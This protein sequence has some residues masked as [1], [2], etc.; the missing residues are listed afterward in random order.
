MATKGKKGGKKKGQTL[1]L[2]EFL[3][4]EGGG[5]YRPPGASGTATVEVGGGAGSTW[6]EEMDDE[7]F[8]YSRPKQQIVLPTAPRAALGPD[9]DDDR[10]PKRPPYTAYIA[11]LPYDVDEEQVTEV[12]ANARLK[13]EQVR[14]M[15]DEG[16]RLRGY[17]YADFQD[18]QSLV[19]VLTMTDLAVNN[20]KMRIDLA[21]QAGKEKGGF[22]GGFG[23]REGGRG[24]EEDPNAGR[25]DTDND[26]R[27]GPAPAPREE[28][29]DSGG[30]DRYNGRSSSD[31]DRGGRDGESRGFSSYEPP[32]DRGGDR[33]GGGGGRY[34]GFS[35]DSGRDGGRDGGGGF[36]RD[37]MTG[38]RGYASRD[39]G[40]ERE[41]PKERP[42]LSLAPRSAAKVDEEGGAAQ[43]SIF[44]GAKPVDTVKKEKEMEEKLLKE[45]EEK[46]KRR[47]EAIKNKP[48]AASIFGGAKPVD[49]S[50]REKEM[51]EKL[52]K[53]TVSKDVD[54]KDER[55]REKPAVE[56]AWRRKDGDSEQAPAR[57]GAYQPPGRREGGERRDERG[58]SGYDRDRRDDRG[59]SGYDRDRRDDRGSDRRDDRGSSGYD[60]DR[61]DDRGSSSGYDRDR[62]DDRG[63]SSGYDRDRRDDRGSSGYDRDRRDERGSSSGYDREK[64][65]DK[66]YDSGGRKDDQDDRNRDDRARSS[67]KEEKKAPTPEPPQLKKYE[68]PIAPDVVAPNKFAFLQEEEVGSG[69]GDEN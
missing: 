61:R 56:N 21:S 23:D 63:S 65:D 44:G 36:S 17:G 24:R 12:F 32:R 33:D 49:T 11:N 31:R 58:S 64:R 46:E 54:R 15:K 22:G 51:E 53:M 14:L 67:D 42:K 27:R 43:S 25:S 68:E 4:G 50:Q 20:R 55:E 10:I 45:K 62:R 18:R 1:N 40:R 38:E 26:W 59:S 2:N 30:T 29:R 3:G 47:E 66:G 7:G 34:G 37:S 57:G 52:A 6:A 39:A 69:S 13:I 41:A 28:G 35:R 9:I 19:D 8:D 60:R 48:S 5:S 16:G